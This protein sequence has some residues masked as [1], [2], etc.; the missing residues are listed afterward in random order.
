MAKIFKVRSPAGIR[1][2]SPSVS[3]PRN[4]AL[5]GINRKCNENPHLMRFPVGVAD[6]AGPARPINRKSERCDCQGPVSPR[7]HYGKTLVQANNI[8]SYDIYCAFL[9]FFLL[10]WTRPLIY[11]L[12][13]GGKCEKKDHCHGVLSSAQKKN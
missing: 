6:L 11:E 5:T 12:E 9:F 10:L 3:F 8:K 4:R 7:P 1:F 2:N 13:E